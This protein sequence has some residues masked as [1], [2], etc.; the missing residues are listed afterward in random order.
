ME[1]HSTVINVWK[2]LPFMISRREFSLGKH[3]QARQKYRK[4]LISVKYTFHGSARKM[5]MLR[6]QFSRR[7]IRRH[8]KP[9]FKE[10]ERIQGNGF[11]VFR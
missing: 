5:K 7:D 9:L 4:C 11:G 8:L 1:A 3:L 10:R 2:N 6:W